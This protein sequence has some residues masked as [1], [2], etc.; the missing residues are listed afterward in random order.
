MTR[1]VFPVA[2][3]TLASSKS[4]QITSLLRQQRRGGRFLSVTLFRR[5]EGGS[6]P[7]LVQVLDLEHVMAFRGVRS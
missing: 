5:I 7:E 2:D 4:N 1:D 3:P 6:S